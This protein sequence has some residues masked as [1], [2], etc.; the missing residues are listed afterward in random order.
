MGWGKTGGFQKGTSLSA[1]K[2]RIE[3]TDFNFAHELKYNIAK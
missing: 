2:I 3:L 1:N